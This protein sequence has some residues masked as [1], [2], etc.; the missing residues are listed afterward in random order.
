[1]HPLLKIHI[2][3]KQFH[4]AYLLCGDAD[5]CREAAMEAAEVILQG[6][7]LGEPKALPLGKVVAH[8][9]FSHCRFDLFGIDDSRELK[10]WAASKSFYGN[11]KVFIIEV[12]AFN[13]ES[14]NALL[15]TLEEPNDGVHFF[16]IAPSAETVMPTLRSRMTVLEFKLGSEDSKPDNLESSLPSFEAAGKFLGSLPN[17]RMETVKKI[18]SEKTV[19][20]TA[21]VEF[22]NNLETI[23][24]KKIRADIK[25]RKNIQ[26]LKELQRSRQFVLDR[27]SSAKM[28]LEH[29]AL[30]LPKF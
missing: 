9:D 3:N 10:N 4:H 17:K 5:V 21:A 7:A 15:K 13:G 25:N 27:G 30:S 12:S 19:D 14:A 26:G 28:I 18:I 16:V 20:K 23:L 2:E 29:L 24:E 11:G 8:P 1:M 22:L 6:N